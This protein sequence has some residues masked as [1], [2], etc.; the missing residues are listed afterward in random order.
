MG[1]Q[2]IPAPKTYEIKCD[3]CG[4]TL[5]VTTNKDPMPQGWNYVRRVYGTGYYDEC[6]VLLCKTCLAK[7]S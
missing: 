6:Q 2:I 7:E 1:I 4:E 3:G 5:I